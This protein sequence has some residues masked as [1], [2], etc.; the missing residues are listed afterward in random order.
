MNFIHLWLH[1]LCLCWVPL[2][3]NSRSAL[4]YVLSH[5]HRT[6][7]L[8]LNFSLCDGKCRRLITYQN[9]YMCGS[10]TAGGVPTSRQRLKNNRRRPCRVSHGA[11]QMLQQV[12]WDCFW[13]SAVRSSAFRD[14]RP[15]YVNSSPLDGFRY[16][17]VTKILLGKLAWFGPS[18]SFRWAYSW[19]QEQW[20]TE[21]M[22]KEAKA[23]LQRPILPSVRSVGLS[24]PH[25][26]IDRKRGH[27]T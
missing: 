4:L 8:S 16:H 27:P 2:N 19:D 6:T 20:S 12:Q 9:V 3:W 11:M 24:P 5:G 21:K 1:I 10:A 7:T 22:R 15:F 17:E 14:L 25:G 26:K 13:I 18:G 23:W